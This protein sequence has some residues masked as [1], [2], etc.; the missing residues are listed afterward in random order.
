MDQLFQLVPAKARKYVYAAA[1]LLTLVWGAWQAADGDWGKAL[2][3]LAG[4]LVAQLAR[5][6]VSAPD[7]TDELDSGA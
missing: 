3:A 6:N 5:A 4:A 1:M 7:S 2:G